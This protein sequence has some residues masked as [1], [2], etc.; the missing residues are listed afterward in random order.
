M[1]PE[2]IRRRLDTIT[3]RIANAVMIVNLIKE[4][5]K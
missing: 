5:S 1:S 2:E 3:E 4:K